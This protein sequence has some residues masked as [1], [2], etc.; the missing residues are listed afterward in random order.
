MKG[1]SPFGGF[2]PNLPSWQKINSAIGL[3]PKYAA[4]GN[5]GRAPGIAG[6]VGN[7]LGLPPEWTDKG[8]KQAAAP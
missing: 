7:K 5:Y 1:K 8:G 6:A 3:A 2:D 4:C